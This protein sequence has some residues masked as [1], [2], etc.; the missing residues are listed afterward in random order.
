MIQCPILPEIYVRAGDYK[1]LEAIFR[2]P[3]GGLVHP[4]NF[5]DDD[6]EAWKYTLSRPSQF[7]ELM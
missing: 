2:G 7:T 6:M 3:E 4:E 5:T 1:F